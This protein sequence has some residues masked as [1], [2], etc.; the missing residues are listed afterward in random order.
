GIPAFVL[1]VN[2]REAGRVVGA[3]SE[4]T[5]RQMLA[6]IPAATA[7]AEAEPAPKRKKWFDV[8]SGRKDPPAAEPPQFAEA[9]SDP[10]VY[11]GQPPEEPSAPA[12]PAAPPAAQNPLETAV[13]IRV[14]DE[15]GIDFGS[16]TVIGSRDG[17]ALVLTCYHIFREFGETA[18]VEVDLFPNGPDSEPQTLP[19]KLIRHD[20]QA[21]VALVVVTGCGV[22]PVSP[23]AGPD[24]FPK[25]RDL[26]FSVGCGEGKAP[27]K[28]Q[29]VVTRLNPYQGPGTTECTGMP[30]VGRSGGGLF[31]AKGRVIGVCFAADR[32]DERGVYVGLAEIHKL[33]EQANFAALIPAPGGDQFAQVEATV[34]PSAEEA[35][36]PSADLGPFAEAAATP[37]AT[38]PADAGEPRPRVTTGA[39]A[40]ALAAIDAG[41]EMEATVILRPLNKPGAPSEVIV[42][43]KVSNRFRRYLKGEL[44]SRP[45][46]TSL[47]MPVRGLDRSRLVTADLLLAAAAPEAYVRSAASRRPAA[48]VA[49]LARVFDNHR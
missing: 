35:A 13:R 45:V 22:L 26:V 20:E 6:K 48:Y 1:V 38:P 17:R 25:E 30:V 3:Q 28:L 44:D 41:E 23:I 7:V 8:L 34:E 27:T 18:A 47:R 19:G 33:L 5:L 32:E 49:L 46:E 15:R 31:D 39:D 9:E 11:R 2:G 37:K 40:D 42:I 29:H 12:A 43:N 21:D 4:V 24:H 14:K 10:P 36:P 16:G